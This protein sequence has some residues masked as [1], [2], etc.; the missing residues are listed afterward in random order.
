MKGIHCDGKG[1]WTRVGYLNMSDDM[2]QDD[3]ELRVCVDEAGENIPL[4]ISE[5]YVY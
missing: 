4:D 5:L 3:I 1:G 2:T